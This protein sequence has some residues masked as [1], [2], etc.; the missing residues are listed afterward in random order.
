MTK[1][2][3]ESGKLHI[4]HNRNSVDLAFLGGG[5][6]GGKYSWYIVACNR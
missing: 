3:V 2:A 5:R 4:I 6:G 1:V